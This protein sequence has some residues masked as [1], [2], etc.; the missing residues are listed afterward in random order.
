MPIDQVNN[1]FGI[2]TP[3]D[4]K[5]KSRQMFENIRGPNDGEQKVPN[6]EEVF[7]EAVHRF[8]GIEQKKGPSFYFFLYKS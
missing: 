8:F 5:A 3:E 6:E 2:E 7:D 1:F 4:V